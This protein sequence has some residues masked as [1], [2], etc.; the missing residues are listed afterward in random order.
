MPRFDHVCQYYSGNIK[1]SKPKGVTLLSTLIKA[2]K[3]PPKRYLNI[4]HAI[5][6]ENDKAKRDQLK[7]KLPSFTPCAF[8]KGRRRYDDI[9]GFTQVA[10][11]DF[12][13]LPDPDYAKEF[14]KAIFDTYPHIYATWLSVSGKGVRAFVR[15]PKVDSV[16]E[17]KQY[18]ASIEKE[19]NQYRG[20]DTATK[21]CILPLFYSIDRGLLYRNYP[22]VWQKK[23]IELE[24]PPQQPPLTPRTGKKSWVIRNA[25]T[26]INKIVDNGHPQLRA[27]AFTVGGYVGG[28]YMS[29]YEAI[30]LMNRLID[31]NAYL[32][33]K[34]KTYKK[35]AETMIKQGQTE[36][37]YFN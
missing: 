30:N 16:D 29:E 18:Y 10:M 33:Q 31:A 3:H 36:P 15:I 32:S 24:P 23:Y 20:F 25:E 19:F 21:N 28:G 27:T 9:S 5:R 6:A 7:I 8:V 35:T 37:L 2:I 11:L 26:A 22:K 14:R 17:F 1:D 4:I 13:G 34:A 12:D